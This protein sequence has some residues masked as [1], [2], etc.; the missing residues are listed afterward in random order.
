[1]KCTLE[2][3]LDRY[4]LD[5]E[6]VDSLT[7]KYFTFRWSP[8]DKTLTMTTR[9]EEMRA[10]VEQFVKETEADEKLTDIFRGFLLRETFINLAEILTSLG[11]NAAITHAKLAVRKHDHH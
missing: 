1:M 10:L 2:F 3:D 7:T 9:P 8:L 6:L 11:E 4:F 5:T